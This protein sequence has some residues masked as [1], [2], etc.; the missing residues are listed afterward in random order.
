M[1]P[2][3]RGGPCEPSLSRVQVLPSP[4]CPARFA[5]CPDIPTLLRF[6][7]IPTNRCS[8][9]FW[10]ILGLVVGAALLAGCDLTGSGG[11]SSS[12]TTVPTT[13]ATTVPPPGSPNEVPTGY[14]SFEQQVLAGVERHDD[15]SLKDG[16]PQIDCVLP[17]SWSP[18]TTFT[19]TVVN[20]AGN[21]VGTVQIA[22]Q[23]P[24]PGQTTTWVQTW[25]PYKSSS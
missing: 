18:G 22:I 23:T 16:N 2:E 10:P 19:C 9:G 15:P 20:G 12:R 25:A 5:R 21:E 6:R 24:N 7:L 13:T 8:G 14:A 1:K 4:T 11:G 3:Q 17:A